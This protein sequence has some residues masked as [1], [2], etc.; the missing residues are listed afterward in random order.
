MQFLRRSA[1]SPDVSPFEHVWYLVGRHLLRD[2]SIAT[3]KDELWLRIQAMWNSLSQVD[4]QELF[5][6]MARHIATL[7]AAHMP[8]TD[9]GS[10]IFFLRKFRHLFVP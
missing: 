3:S 4:I 9:F 5:G 10:L 8:N 6:S 1:Y 2:S 7:I